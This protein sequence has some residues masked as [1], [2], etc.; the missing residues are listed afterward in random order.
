MSY[1]WV[2][3]KFIEWPDTDISPDILVGSD[4][5]FPLCN[6]CIRYCH[7]LQLV[8]QNF[9]EGSD[10]DTSPDILTGSDQQFS[11]CNCCIGYYQVLQ[12]VNLNFIEGL[13]TDTSPNILTWQSA[14]HTLQQ[15]HKIVS[16]LTMCW[17]WI[18]NHTRTYQRLQSKWTLSLCHYNLIYMEMNPLNKLDR[19]WFI[20]WLMTCMPWYSN[21]R[22]GIVYQIYL[23]LPGPC[24]F[25]DVSLTTSLRW[26]TQTDSERCCHGIHWVTCTFKFKL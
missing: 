5:Q 7:V 2:H 6:C 9:I 3:Q 16:G 19:V 17:S 14:I 25:P 13:D 12:P 10:T 18:L 1:N 4:Q 26:L 22:V 11:L 20:T 23:C 24:H 21:G 8:D 15:L